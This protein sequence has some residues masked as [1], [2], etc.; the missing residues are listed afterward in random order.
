MRV[1][2]SITGVALALGLALAAPAGATV[3]DHTHFTDSQPPTAEDF[4]GITVLHA[5]DVSGVLTLRAIKGED[6]AAAF[7]GGSVA[8]FTDTFTN[9]ATGRTIT[10]SGHSNYRD[11]K[12]TRLSGTI[13]QFVSI[14]AGR[15]FML[16]ADDGTVIYRDRGVIRRTYT[17]DVGDDNQPGGTFLD[18]LDVQ[19]SG[20]H[21]GFDVTDEEFC[22][23]ALGALS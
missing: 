19:V 18:L 7:T 15:P 2:S 14:E 8:T 22:A 1:R 3:V 16:T 13:F 21:P 20:P 9:E 5:Y 6:A 4:C 23:A 11:I 17:F 12:A 10:I